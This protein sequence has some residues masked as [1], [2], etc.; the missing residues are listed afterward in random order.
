MGSMTSRIKLHRT[1]L[2]TIEE[3]LEQSP[4][5]NIIHYSCESFYDRPE[6]RTPRVTSIAVRNM[7]TGQTHSFSIHKTAELLNVESNK[8]SEMY[9]R[10]E[11]DMLGEFF[12]FVKR[13]EGYRWLHW[14]MR[15][16]N[17]GFAAIEH[18]FRVLGGTPIL[19]DDSK[20]YDLAGILIDA[21]GVRYVGHPRLT[22]LL[23]KNKITS[24][25]YLTGAQEAEAFEKKEYVRLHQSTLRKVDVM[26]NIII[27][28]GDG[29]L[30]T[31]A[32][33]HEIYGMSW[34][35][36]G[37]LIKEHWVFVI[38]AFLFSVISL[39]IGIFK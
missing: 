12:E 19:I 25:N 24:L 33:W 6:G 37:E 31:N 15:D 35:S 21:Y 32:R 1:A 39:V 36:V 16:I 23:E 13:H 22:K 3:L 26:S 8:I 29:S 28:T 27:R 5:V 4:S 7:K 11:K 17:Y 9:D 2:K 18:R 34:Q 10:L 14:N 30:K 38:I 20:K